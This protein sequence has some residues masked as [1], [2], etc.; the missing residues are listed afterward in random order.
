MNNIARLP[1]FDRNQQ[2]VAYEI[3]CQTVPPSCAPG[4]SAKPTGILEALREIGMEELCG[5]QPAYITVTR[6]LLI[7]DKLLEMAPN[8]IAVE[9]PGNIEPDGKVIDACK[10]LRTL[11]FPI[12]LD[13]FVFSERADRIL[14]LADIVKLDVRTT[15]TYD[16]QWLFAHYA[17]ELKIL[18][19]GVDTREQFEDALQQGFTYFQG[20]FFWERSLKS[21]NELAVSRLQYLRLL[22]AVGAADLDFRQLE[23]LIKTDVALCFRLLRYLNSAIFCFHSSVTSIRHALA[24][25]GEQEIRKWISMTAVAMSAGGKTNEVLMVS[26]LRARFCE[27][28]AP[29]VH[30]NA[31][32]LFVVGLFSL[33]D[34][35]VQMPMSQ[36]LT[37]VELP[38]ESY[39][40]LLGCHC[41][42][43]EVL[44]LVLAYCRGDWPE[45]SRL[46]AALGISESDMSAA[47]ISTIRWVNAVTQPGGSARKDPLSV[48]PTERNEVS[49]G[50]EP[51]QQISY[52]PGLKARCFHLKCLKQD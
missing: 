26:L 4:E 21:P 43:R 51:N 41:R 17:A 15:P 24:L 46:C 44:D 7:E 8:A 35:I 22:E 29:L 16:I 14:P 45:S 33:M 2:K 5:K 13:N 18:A 25:L 37:Q 48:K 36:I 39:K 32:N 6:E 30:C 20:E 31:Y 42:V 49:D 23:K 10:R 3:V 27:L 38:P 50:R 52:E 12:V 19:K 34:A 28:L 47:Y 40:A 11:R 1:I 9:L